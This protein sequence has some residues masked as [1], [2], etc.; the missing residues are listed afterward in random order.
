MTPQSTVAAAREEPRPPILSNANDITPTRQFLEALFGI[1][2]PGTFAEM[3]CFDK[4]RGRPQQRW[5]ELPEG[6]DY[7]ADQIAATEMP[8]YIGA[9]PRGSRDG[10]DEAV[11]EFLS[12]YADLDAQNLP[13]DQAALE[14]LTE[15]FA[16]APSALI[17]TSPGRYQSWW[18]LQEAA[19]KSEAQRVRR[20]I[21]TL[22]EKLGGDSTVQNAGRVMRPAGSLNTKHDPPFRARLALL[23]PD[24]RYG[25]D[26]IEDALPCDTAA[27]RPVLHAVST[28]P[29]EDVRPSGTSQKIGEGKRNAYLA[30]T[31][32]RV[33]RTG[34]SPEAIKAAV[35]AE[36]AK[37]CDPP[38]PASEV[39]SVVQSIER[40]REP[41]QLWS[42][43]QPLPAVAEAPALPVE[44]VPEPLRAWCI[45][46]AESAWLPPEWFAL[47]A[48]TVCGGV[49]APRLA[50]RP[51]TSSNH[52][53][54]PNF[55]CMIAAPPGSMKSSVLDAATAPLQRLAGELLEKWHADGEPAQIADQKDLDAQIKGVEK[56]LGASGSSAP[57]A[58]E[59]AYLREQLKESVAKRREVER[60]GPRRLVTSDATAEKIGQ[61]L[62]SVPPDG[63]PQSLIVVRDELQGLLS[64]FERAGREGER[65]LFL[66]AANGAGSFTYDRVGRGTL[67]IERLCLGIIGTIQPARLSKLLAAAKDDGDD[68]LA[69][70][71]QLICKS[72]LPVY[73]RPAAAI[74]PAVLS[75]YERIIR[76]LHAIASDPQRIAAEP[77]TDGD[78]PALRFAADAQKLADDWRFDL[79]TTLRSGELPPVLQAHIGKYR[80]L[81]PQLA[82]IEHL[83][84]DSSGAE[85]T[86]GS[87]QWSAS[88][89]SWLQEHA[90]A[91]YGC[92]DETERAGRALA[93]R[94]EAGDVADDISV[95]DIERHGWSDLT[96]PDQVRSGVEWLEQLGWCRIEISSVPKQG[97]RPSQRLRVNPAASA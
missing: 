2:T 53:E 3:R 80:G 95:R 66:Q 65:Q 40:Y 16:L 88:F 51:W 97:G 48:L 58:A 42:E 73:T 63:G 54:T 23:E 46:Q 50:I 83:L 36:N 94:I 43:L 25:L 26:E 8:A 74:D 13:S 29:S 44:L 52:V 32:G 4:D 79:E 21:A 47:A 9:Q 31:A 68:G 55:W 67:Q 75:D 92:G 96:T 84:R 5:R 41:E 57:D 11:C 89:C 76:R 10:R 72:G 70:R 17:Q 64:T 69:A 19:P 30:T 22:A 18:L 62:A 45:A 27:E 28:D 93:A 87:V 60:R 82:L 49:I 81:M 56:Q 38:L 35:A 86:E 61:I 15:R 37:R 91:S 6:I 59:R 90:S 24:R 34:V 77:V 33:Q 12:I 85:V 39:E 1:A 7:L 78:I 71:F 20:V 14:Y